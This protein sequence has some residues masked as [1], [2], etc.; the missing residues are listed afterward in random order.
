MLRTL[1]LVRSEECGAHNL[2]KPRVLFLG[3]RWRIQWYVGVYQSRDETVSLCR[4]DLNSSTRCIIP[5]IYGSE[6]SSLYTCNTSW[7]YVHYMILNKPLV[8]LTTVHYQSTVIMISF[9]QVLTAQWSNTIPCWNVQFQVGITS[10]NIQFQH[11]HHYI[12]EQYKDKVKVVEP[13][14]IAGIDNPAD[15]FTKSLPVVKV[16]QFRS[17]IR[18]S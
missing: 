9:A 15:L 18:L 8:R 5:Y 13:F 2:L 14:H 1:Y 3:P 11:Q 6:S 7:H 17:K 4:P 16:E 12:L 10:H